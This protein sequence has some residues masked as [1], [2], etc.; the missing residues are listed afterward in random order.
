[1]IYHKPRFRLSIFMNREQYLLDLNYLKAIVKLLCMEYTIV[2]YGLIIT[3]VKSP[4][5]TVMRISNCLETIA[6]LPDPYHNLSF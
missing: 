5:G 6:N 3:A 1:M 4:S 2:L